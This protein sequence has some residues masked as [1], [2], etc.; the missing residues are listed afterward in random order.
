MMQIREAKSEIRADKKCKTEDDLFQNSHI[1]CDRACVAA[2]TDIKKTIERAK[3]VNWQT[4]SHAIIKMKI[5]VTYQNASFKKQ[6]NMEKLIRKRI[7][8]IWWEFI[9]NVK[10]NVVVLLIML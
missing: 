10:I 9:I 5:S 1:F 3:N 7:M 4:V 6:N 8:S 2:M